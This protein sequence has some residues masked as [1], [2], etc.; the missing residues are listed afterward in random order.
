MSGHAVAEIGHLAQKSQLITVA[1][2]WR[3]AL[4]IVRLKFPQNMV[5]KHKTVAMILVLR[6]TFL[7]VIRQAENH[8]VVIRLRYLL[9]SEFFQGAVTNIN[10]AIQAGKQI[11]AGWILLK[12][13]ILLIVNVMH[14]I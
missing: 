10:I 13:D 8:D 3:I 6:K 5:V 12:Q 7:D 9:L 11:Q 1:D 4:Q 2:W 14:K